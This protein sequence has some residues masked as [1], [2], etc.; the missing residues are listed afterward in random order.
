MKQILHILA[1][2]MRRFWGEILLSLA[3]TVAFAWVVSRQWAN[4][5]NLVAVGQV[6][7]ARQDAILTVFLALL[8]PISWWLLIARVAHDERTV[9]DR[10]FWITRPYEWKKLLAAKAL[11][12]VCFIYL[13]ITVAQFC[14]EAL[15]GLHPLA[16]VGGFLY[17]MMLLSALIFPLLAIATVTVNFARMTL[18]LLCIAVAAAAIAIAVSALLMKGVLHSPVSIENPIAFPLLL[19]VCAGVIALQYAA[20]RVALSRIIMLALPFLLAL[21]VWVFASDAMVNHKYPHATIGE[22]AAVQLTLGANAETAGD[23]HRALSSGSVQ[24]VLPLHVA[25]VAEGDLW[26]PNGVKVTVENSRGVSLTSSWQPVNDWYFRPDTQDANVTFEVPRNLFNRVQSTPVTLR[27]A[28]ALTEARRTSVWSRTLPG[29]DFEVPDFGICSPRVIPVLIGAAEVP[30]IESIFCRS[31]QRQPTLT[32]VETQWSGGP[33]N[34]LP[35]G[36]STAGQ[37][38][39]W[40]GNLKTEP[41]ESSFSAVT[42][43]PIG[44]S[45]RMGSDNHLCPGTPITYSEYRT[46]RLM[47]TELTAQNFRFPSYR[48]HRDPGWPQPQ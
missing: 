1:K 46:V 22:N 4:P 30:Q 5:G 35:A 20:R 28:F 6:A 12:V 45:I 21:S 11:F 25:G 34:S 40:V 26:V 23:A 19:C 37:A 10:Q 41:A 18:T 39:A 33:C 16:H 17:Q 44:F 43:F 29:H 36:S 47:Q 32:Y 24:V 2:D 27:L 38:A 14:L 48:E 9:G 42:M 8:I 3:V 15:A 7:F 13:P 31:A